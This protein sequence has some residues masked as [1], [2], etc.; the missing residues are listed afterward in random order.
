MA[1]RQYRMLDTNEQQDGIVQTYLANERDHYLHTKNLERFALMLTTLPT[2]LFRERIQ[3]L[4]DET[5]SRLEEVNAILD[6]TTPQLPPQAAIIASL[7]RL[8]A[9]GVV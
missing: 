1:E 5:A 6:A 4:H 9:R 3:H 2:G 7:T 8:Q